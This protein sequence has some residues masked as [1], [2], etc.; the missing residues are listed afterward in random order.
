MKKQ[1]LTA[2]LFRLAPLLLCAL[3]FFPPTPASAQPYFNSFRP[4]DSLAKKL[5][6]PFKA[7]Q[8]LILIPLFL[9]HSDTLWFILDSGVRN[10]ILF[11]MPEKDSLQMTG[12]RVLQIGGLGT[13]ENVSVL[14]TYNNIIQIPGITG[15]NQD[16]LL[17]NDS[18]FKIK[19][20]LA[21]NVH[22]IIGYALFKDFIVEINYPEERLTLYRPSAFRPK[23][24]GRELEFEL[25]DQKPFIEVPVTFSHGKSSLH[26][27]L[28]DSGAGFSAALFLS[29]QE[30]KAIGSSGIYGTLG[31]G[32]NGHMK[33]YLSR[34]E[35][36]QLGP[37]LIRNPLITFPDSMATGKGRLPEYHIGIIGMDILKRFHLT[38]SYPDQKIWLKKNRMFRNHFLYNSSGIEIER[39]FEN[40]PLYMVKEVREGS[41]AARAGILPGDQLVEVNGKESKEME[42]SELIGLFSGRPHKRLKITVLRNGEELHFRFRIPDEL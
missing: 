9:N 2:L 21:V 42:L 34:I 12:S 30:R 29:G 3:L 15:M 33:G 35:A 10:T 24:R 1:L 40:L 17:V 23:G 11:R 31:Y 7:T 18:T 32:L 27:L 13:G 4:D 26:K 22:G 20:R 25:I 41:V 8:N 37:Y 5:V 39:P 14:H 38:I 19:N 16:V 36:L 28:L 6:I